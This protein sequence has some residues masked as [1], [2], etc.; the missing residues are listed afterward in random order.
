[1]SGSGIGRRD[2]Y[3]VNKAVRGCCGAMALEIRSGSRQS[4]GIQPPGEVKVLG[5]ARPKESI[6][7]S[8]MVC[9]NSELLSRPLQPRR[10]RYLV[11]DRRLP[12]SHSHRPWRLVTTALPREYTTQPCRTG[13]T[14]TNPPSP[15]RPTTPRYRQ[16]HPRTGRQL[17]QAWRGSAAAP[18]ARRSSLAWRADCGVRV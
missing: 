2:Q 11:F 15:R 16:R 6:G 14:R 5:R 9:L 13:I 18:S 17:R 10:R 3:G 7:G 1:V 4:R 8:R 12:L